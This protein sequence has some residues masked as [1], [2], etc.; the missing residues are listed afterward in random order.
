MDDRHPP[1]VEFV[2]DGDAE[3]AFQAEHFAEVASHQLR[4]AVHRADELQ[5]LLRP[6]PAAPP[7]ARSRPVHIG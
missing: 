3:L 6:E 7:R 4:I 1:S 5:I 2:A